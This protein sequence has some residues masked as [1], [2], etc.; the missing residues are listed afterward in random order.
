M[1]DSPDQ[2]FR[3]P[4]KTIDTGPATKSQKIGIVAAW[5]EAHGTR[6]FGPL[7]D[8]EKMAPAT[9]S[10]TPTKGTLF[11]YFGPALWEGN[12]RTPEMPTMDKV[13]QEFGLTQDNIDKVGCYCVHQ[14][15]TALG[16][17]VAYMLRS[18]TGV[19]NNP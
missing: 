10:K 15:G 11:E 1:F 13:M 5:F 16:S 9:L 8:V 4:A 19:G 18:V 12:I 2:V 3:V 17:H 7:L 6:R 14:T